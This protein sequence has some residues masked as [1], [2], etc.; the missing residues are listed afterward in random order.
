MNRLQALSCAGAALLALAGAA[1][2]QDTTGATGQNATARKPDL[3]GPVSALSPD[4]LYQGWRARQLLGDRVTTKDG[5][6]IGAVSDIVV[7]ADGRAAALVVEG[8]GTVQVPDAVYRIPWENID[9]TPGQDGVIVDLSAGPQP[10]YALFPGTSGVPTL[11]REF[12][13]QEVVGDYARL[14]TGYGYGIVTGAV[15][16]RDGRIIAVLISRDASAGGGTAAFPFQGATGPWDAS[17]SYFGLPFI[18]DD[19]AREAGLRIDPSR[20]ANKAI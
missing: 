12:R 11:P 18:T 5:R 15:F 8:G 6:E 16:A 7:D 10:R 14:R 4:A 13:I 3:I 20:F 1:H 17:M 9:L 19:Q 2:A